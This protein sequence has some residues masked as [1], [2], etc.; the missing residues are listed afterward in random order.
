[1]DLVP[2]N[3][4]EGVQVAQCQSHL[5]CIEHSPGLRKGTLPLEVVEELRT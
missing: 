5:C 1:M 4:A 3:N 2:V